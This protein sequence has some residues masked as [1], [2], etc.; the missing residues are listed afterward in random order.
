MFGVVVL[1]CAKR[2]LVD[3]V[4]SHLISDRDNAPPLA[5]SSAKLAQFVASSEDCGPCNYFVV[6][7]SLR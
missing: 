6:V 7:T 5:A 2:S 3:H 1:A 4:A